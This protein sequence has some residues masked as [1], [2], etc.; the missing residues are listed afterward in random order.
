MQ[1]TVQYAQLD[2][3]DVTENELNKIIPSEEEFKEDIN[4]AEAEYAHCTE[5]QRFQEM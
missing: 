5:L 3:E 1:H 4:E 2:I